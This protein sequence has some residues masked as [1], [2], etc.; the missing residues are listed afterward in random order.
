MCLFFIYTIFPILNL[1]HSIQS[2][3]VL[4]ST[5]KGAVLTKTTPQ[6]SDKFRHLSLYN[7]GL[8]FVNPNKNSIDDRIQTLK[9]ERCKAFLAKFT[10]FA[11]KNY[12]K[13]EN[14]SN[15]A[16]R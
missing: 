14:Y 6:L 4:L 7:I 11:V 2:K 5:K 1:F 10:T 9:N 12:V 13:K 16:Q 3:T 8:L 15:A